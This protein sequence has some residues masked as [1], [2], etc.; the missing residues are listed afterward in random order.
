MLYGFIAL[1][2]K[3]D[4]HHSVAFTYCLMVSVLSR[5]SVF[6]VTIP[7]QTP[8]GSH[9]ILSV[10]IYLVTTSVVIKESDIRLSRSR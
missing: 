9:T 3:Q 6:Y 1:K 2:L 10:Y 5:N 7:T 8:V 4:L